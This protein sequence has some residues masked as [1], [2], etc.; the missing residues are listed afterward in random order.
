MFRRCSQGARLPLDVLLLY[1]RTFDANH[2]FNAIL[3]SPV[4]DI[5]IGFEGHVVRYDFAQRVDHTL[6]L[7]AHLNGFDLFLYLQMITV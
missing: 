2:S 5:D 6:S 1:S 4:I 3:Q 7:H